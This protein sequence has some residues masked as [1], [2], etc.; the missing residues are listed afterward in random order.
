[1]T[2]QADQTI[3]IKYILDAQDAINKAKSLEAETEKIRTQLQLMAATSGKSFK[4]LAAAMQTQKLE[5]Y[6]A[7][8]AG[9]KAE[10]KANL[11]TVKNNAVGIA[12]Y[13]QKAVNDMNA[14]T[15]AYNQT[16]RAINQA[17][18]Q[19]Q[20]ANRQFQQAGGS[21]QAV[22][23]IGTAA[24]TS[25][26]SFGVLGQA[27][28][29]AL[30]L[31][32]VQI[33]NKVI[34][35]IG[36]LIQYLNAATQSGYEFAKGMYQLQVG[37]NAL[38]RAG[39]EIT[40][41]EV[42][43]QLQKLKTEF[44]IF[45]T[46]DLVVGASAFL[47]LNRDMGFTKD[48][49]F[50]LQDA[51]ATL[52]VVNG[53]AM[54]EVQKTVALALSSGYTEGLQRLGVSINRVTIAEEAARL[55]W[56]KGYTALT[57]QQRALAT[58][59][60]VLEKTSVYAADLLMYQETL[61]GQIDVLT[62]AIVDVNAKTGEGLLVV[63]KRI[64]EIKLMWA[65]FLS[66][67]VE[68][69]P[70]LKMLEREDLIEE[71][72]G[73]TKPDIQYILEPILKVSPSN[74]PITYF[75]DLAE[76]IEEAT[77]RAD[78]MNKLNMSIMN[79]GVPR[80]DK[81]ERDF[82]DIGK[83]DI[84]IFT[85]DQIEAIEAAG[86][87]IL[88]LQA[89]YD[90]DRRDLEIDLQRDLARIEAEGAEKIEDIM[91][92]HAQKM[93][94][95]AN[96]TRDSI[97]NLEA[98]YALDVQQAWDDYYNNV[99]SAAESNTNKLLKIEEDYQEKLKR[100][101]EGFLLDMEDALQ[102]RDARQVLQLIRRYNLEKTQATRER[103]NEIRE[104]NRAYQEQ[105]HE[106]E[107]QRNARLKK[108]KE[109][110]DLRERMLIEQR[111]REL[112]LETEA[113]L[114]KMAQQEEENKKDIDARKLKYQQ[115]LDDLNL[116]LQDRLGVLARGLIEENGI[117]ASGLSAMLDI[118]L[119]YLGPEGA[120]TQVYMNFA[121]AAQAAIAAAMAGIAGLMVLP[122]S[123]PVVPPNGPHTGP[124]AQGGIE[125]ANKPTTAV[126]GEA[127]P[128]LALFLPLR[129][130]IGSI[131]SSTNAAPMPEMR[132]GDKGKLMVEIL[133]GAGL[134]GKIIDRALN[135]VASVVL[136]SVRS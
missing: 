72:S 100:L 36:Q 54:D 112:K 123:L 67:W 106:L 27:I 91:A 50:K 11:D 110:L 62:A 86:E 7:A 45:A 52:A 79:M 64:T 88:A 55:G 30:G 10:L 69:S 51:I 75:K 49:L 5:Q 122:G 78:A 29:T 73:K 40:F 87:K 97:N 135:N 39:T 115:D 57:E 34:Q 133:L 22:G 131:S 63:K 2:D 99:A 93:L 37:V 107:R 81:G 46:K 70:T 125:Y 71:V 41:G 103:D 16:G 83:E 94:D 18:Q 42:L 28:G 128:E 19:L 14:V 117:T 33:I 109:E 132:Q 47:N 32:T 68:N 80:I 3:I 84:S 121:A 102:A 4:D 56:D 95:I 6:K 124:H 74:N 65:E 58:Y 53:R 24:R 13:Q 104:Q 59:N 21:A 35:S 9:I 105:L 101:K 96:K 44:G 48:Q 61:P 130:G 12:D 1:M 66:W 25:A 17:S 38:R 15:A 60:L 120:A 92:S 8:V 116:H 114:H 119:S 85:D 136:R 82:V 134:E 118:I 108:L 23:Q 126:F 127:G 111:D 89:Q 113:Y 98:Q 31:G 76:A 43:T 26:G 77:K 90:I 20:Q 129:G